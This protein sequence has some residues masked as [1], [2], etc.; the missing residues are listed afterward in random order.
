MKLIRIIADYYRIGK[1]SYI[2]YNVTMPSGDYLSF[3]I[4]ARS[5]KRISG[6]SKELRLISSNKLSFL[7]VPEK[8]KLNSSSVFGIDSELLKQKIKEADSAKD[9][10]L[11]F[12]NSV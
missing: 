9:R 1:E 5:N 7:P 11:K 12:L 4:P 3:W 8:G 10:I 2:E 6:K